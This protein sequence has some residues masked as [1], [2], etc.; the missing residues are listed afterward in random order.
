MKGA[1]RIALR[2]ARDADGAAVA[3]LI[4]RVLSEYEGCL[5]IPSEF[6]ELAAPASHYAAHGGGMWVAA[7]RGEIVGSVA[8]SINR[9]PDVFELHKFY[10]DASERGSGLAA[11]LFAHAADAAREGG[12]REIVLFSD[13]RFKRGHAFYE[14]HGF[15]PLPGARLLHDASHSLEFGFRKPLVAG[16]HG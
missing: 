16:A 6:P 2:P 1:E 9:P 7:R 3:A 13:T 11:T 15:T 8:T 5:Y 14:K 10:V 12:G 4:A